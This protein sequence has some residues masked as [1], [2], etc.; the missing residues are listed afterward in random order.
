MVTLYTNTGLAKTPEGAIRDCRIHKGKRK[1]FSR[2]GSAAESHHFSEL[3][4][5]II[6]LSLS[7]S[8]LKAL[9]ISSSKL[10]IPE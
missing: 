5:V 10:V 1:R 4:K 6:P 7:T 9:T 8:S 3:G 2:R